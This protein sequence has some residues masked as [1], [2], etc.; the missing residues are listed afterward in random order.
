MEIFTEDFNACDS[1]L[2]PLLSLIHEI[3]QEKLGTMLDKMSRIQKMVGKLS[4]ALGMDN[5]V[6][7]VV[8]HAAA[9]AMS[10]LATS[11][12]TEFTSLSGIMARHYALRDGYPE[13]V[14][15]QQSS[16]YCYSLC[17]NLENRDVLHDWLS[18]FK[19]VTKLP[20]KYYCIC[21]NAWY[22]SFGINFIWVSKGCRKL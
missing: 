3:E 8:D 1:F 15:G 7:E 6:I 13:Q 9:L 12:V 20:P 10:D 17:E 11:V 5:D 14:C 21:T 19:Q 16:A 18:C 2:P 22:F 4:L